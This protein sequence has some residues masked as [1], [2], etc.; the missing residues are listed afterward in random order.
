MSCILKYISFL[1]LKKIYEFIL[2]WFKLKMQ[3]MGV[4]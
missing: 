2:N 4:D 1:F 3:K